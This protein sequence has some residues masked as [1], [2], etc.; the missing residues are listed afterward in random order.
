MI[1]RAW[2]VLL[3]MLN[4]MGSQAYQSQGSLSGTVTDAQTGE[5]IPGATIQL[6][7]TSLGAI[8]DENGFYN[9]K[10]IP[11]RTYSVQAS[12]VGYETVVKYNVVIRSGGTPDLNF[13]L[14]EA[15]SQLGE[16]VITANPFEK[17]VETPLSIQK[18]SAEEIATYPGGNNDIAKVVQ[19][20]P[21][22]SGSVGGFRN[23]IIIRGG[24]PN[25]NVYYLDGI[26]IPNINHFA[27][28]GSAGGPV[29]M[30]NVSF[31]EG[32]TLSTSAFGAE[33]DNVLSG[34]LQFDQ[35]NGN[36]RE[37]KTNLRVGSSE[38]AL[39]FEGPLFKKGAEASRTSFIVSARRSYL[40][41]LFEL[42]GLPILPDY[43]DYQ[44]KLSHEIDEYNE[45]IVTGIGSI[46][47]FRVNELD[48]FDAE[49]QATQDQVP[50]I[51]QQT[52]TV[53]ISW[54]SR[55]KNNSGFTTLALSNNRLENDFRQYTD[56]INQTGLFLQ[57][58]STESETKLRFN[59]TKFSGDWTLSAGTSLQLA[60]YDNETMDLVNNVDYNSSLNFSRYGFFGQANR[61]YL[62]DRLNLSLGLRL[63]GN[64]FT[65][66]G[67]DLW[68]TFSPRISASY[69]FDEARKWS[70]NAS[71]GRYFKLPPYTILGFSDNSGALINQGA[72]Y[73]R[74]DHAVMGLEYLVTPTARITMEG[75]FK[76][77]ADYPVSVNDQVSLANLGGDFSVLGNEAI[78][79]TGQGRTYGIEL[80]YQK[81]FTNN[82]YAILAY[83]LY[84]SEFTALDEDNYLPSAWDSRHLLTF[85]GGYKWGK[86]WELSTRMR[87]LGKT[88]Y[89]P[90]DQQ[91]T[92]DN[93]PSI[94]RDY[95][96]LGSVRLDTFN[97]TDIRIDKKWN[98]EG[99]TLDIFLEVQNFFG[100]QIPDAPEYGLN[101]DEDG[102]VVMPRSL[103]RINE[104]DNS[105]VLPSLGLVIDF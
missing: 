17:I 81:K 51:K 14:K 63:D 1:I 2:L 94:I 38:T 36:N 48:E 54:K 37:L 28:Q 12:F 95:S 31:F 57:N 13:Q 18:L 30:L 100:Q 59:Y 41:L 83:T 79:S 74:S 66:Q 49:Q 23:D 8:S 15:V 82:W 84:K 80:L 40:Q 16:V 91:A 71:L 105:S 104:I 29:G 93:Y 97:R 45:L 6:I 47:D 19:S 70:V 90:V 55:F 22:V 27:T 102:M 69:T 87:F 98:F 89:A 101:R 4:V 86:N 44:Y 39:T 33:Y 65:T 64:D 42:I 56:N 99:W 77:Y 21:G 5:T 11:A 96:L 60:S 10:N 7:E 62:D 68:R 67:N 103:V 58:I 24:A 92:L 9:I 26:E 32:V 73:I 72:D 3:G 43:W 53:G 46:D 50:I 88:P 78:T 76:R 85:T 20:L 35:R 61:S 25:E 75:F 52:N 34:V